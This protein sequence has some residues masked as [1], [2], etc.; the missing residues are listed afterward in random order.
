MVMSLAS[1]ESMR[2]K[3]GVGNLRYAAK[4]RACFMVLKAASWVGPQESVLGL[5]LRAA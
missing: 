3:P 1:V 5:P 2:G 4:E